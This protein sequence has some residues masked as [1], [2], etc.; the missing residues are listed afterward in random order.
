MTYGGGW[1]SKHKLGDTPLV[2]YTA[3]ACAETLRN[4]VIMNSH[5]LH[6]AGQ[7]Q[8]QHLNSLQ[9]QPRLHRN[10]NG[11]L[12]RISPRQTGLP[13]TAARQADRRHTTAANT[14][15]CPPYTDPAGNRL[16][17]GAAGRHPQH[18]ADGSPIASQHPLLFTGTDR[19]GRPDGKPTHIREGVIARMMSGLT[20]TITTAGAGWCIHADTICRRWSKSLSFTTL[21][22]AGWQNRYGGVNRT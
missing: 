21:G 19:H 14:D 22:P 4:P 5:R 11:R 2:E 12:R 13:A 3:T 20:G 1:L 6:S 9:C 7:L 8:N 16:P 10:D 15:I 18:V 17:T